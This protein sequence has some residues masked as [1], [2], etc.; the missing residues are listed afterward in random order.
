MDER[1]TSV[2]LITLRI[3]ICESFL[4]EA[5]TLAHSSLRKHGW[6]SW[7]N[8]SIQ[9]WRATS[10]NHLGHKSR[11]VFISNLKTNIRVG[12][13]NVGRSQP[14]S[15]SKTICRIALARTV[16]RELRVLNN[17]MIFRYSKSLQATWLRHNLIRS[18]N[19]FFIPR[20]NKPCSIF[21]KKEEALPNV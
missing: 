3:G 21:V 2:P 16:R 11:V 5:A 12:E 13:I 20:L 19:N 8:D 6:L 9:L 14:N 7:H 17:L 18:W 10:R 4:E 1:A 15:S